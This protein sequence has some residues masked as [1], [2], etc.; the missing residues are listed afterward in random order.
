MP[1]QVVFLSVIHYSA[2]RDFSGLFFMPVSTPLYG[3]GCGLA[4]GLVQL[5]EASQ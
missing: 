1:V 3:A 2:G 5:T 4:A